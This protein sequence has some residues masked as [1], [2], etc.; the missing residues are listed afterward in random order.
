MRAL[1]LPE[2]LRAAGLR[3]ELVP[4]WEGRG[5]ELSGIE[6]VICHHTAGPAKGDHPSLD[7]VTNGR[8]DLAGPLSQLVLGRGGTFFVVA[9]GRANHAGRGS[10]NGITD[11]NGRLL[12]I[13]AENTGRPDDPWPAE[14]MAAYRL[15]VAAILRHLGLPAGAVAGHKEYALPAGRKPDPTF[16]M[17][18]FRRGVAAI[19]AGPTSPRSSEDDMFDPTDRKTLATIVDDLDQLKRRSVRLVKSDKDGSHHLIIAGVLRAPVPP[20]AVGAYQ[21]ALRFGTPEVWGHATLM[22]IPLAGT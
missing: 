16:D 17:P 7:T 10:W 8:P 12:G 11:G 20:D 1:W 21:A 9:A 19:L 22:A 15:G 6:G 13:E 14:Q 4:G 5:R 18:T 3:V 2:V